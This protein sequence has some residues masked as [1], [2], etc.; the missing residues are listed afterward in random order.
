[1]T[2]RGLPVIKAPS[3][4]T[5]EEAPC[6]SARLEEELEKLTIEHRRQK[7]QQDCHERSKSIANQL[8]PRTTARRALATPANHPHPVNRQTLPSHNGAGAK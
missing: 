4:S 7:R 1:M 5:F 8:K 3:V 2:S 6:P